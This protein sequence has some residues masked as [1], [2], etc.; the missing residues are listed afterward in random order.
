MAIA[1]KVEATHR[2]LSL[3]AWKFLEYVEENPETTRFVD[4]R[5]DP[6]L[7]R[8]MKDPYPLQT[9][10]VLVGARKLTQIRRAA[11]EV[12]RLLKSIPERLDCPG[13]IAKAYGIEDEH[14]ASLY[15][16][17]PTGLDSAL[18]RCDFIDDG[19]NLFCIEMNLSPSL[20]GWQLCLFQQAC[21]DNGPVKSFI[22]EEAIRPRFRDSLKSLFDFIVRDSLSK[23]VV[24]GRQMNIL[25][26]F[27]SEQLRIVRQSEAFFG[28]VCRKVLEENGIEG[29]VAYCEY[30]TRTLNVEDGELHYRGKHV[31]AVVEFCEEATPREVFMPFKMG[32][33]TLYNGPAATAIGSKLSSCLLSELEDSDLF[34]AEE[35]ATI[36]SHIPWSRRIADTTTTFQGDRVLLP[37]FLLDQKD[38]FIIKPMDGTRGE[39]VVVGRLTDEKKWQAWVERACRQ[40]GWMAQAHVDSRPYLFQQGEEGY[41][42]FDLVWG[43]FCFGQ[44]YGGGFLRMAPKGQ[45]SG[46]INAAL[47]ATEGILFELNE[48]HY[49]ECQRNQGERRGRNE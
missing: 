28:D 48:E 35:R 30:P 32:T 11:T 42:V 16:A 13:E 20:G 6:S 9:W 33:A 3:K 10:P 17:P 22:N 36:R 44:E 26:C 14:L 47:G 45:H 39:N 31:H 8:W 27:S 29:N 46:V 2:D 40:G 4:L 49:D 25:F 24:T 19:D 5:E 1:E 43:T 15:F 12:P 41:G 38:Q 7:P 21:L 37:G 23:G 18:C 34:S